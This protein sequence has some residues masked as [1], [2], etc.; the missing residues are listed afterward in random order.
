MIVAGRSNVASCSSVPLIKLAGLERAARF[1]GE[2]FGHED[3]A[4]HETLR[5]RMLPAPSRWLW[6]LA[7]T[8]AL[9]GLIG[10]SLR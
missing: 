10:L 1:A 7:A 4:G 2:T 5:Q 9:A 3:L 8:V 6:W